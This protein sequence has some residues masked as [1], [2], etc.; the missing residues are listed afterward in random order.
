MKMET[1]P[2]KR[3]ILFGREIL[4]FRLNELFYSNLALLIPTFGLISTWHFFNGQ[5]LWANRKL[6]RNFCISIDNFRF[7][8][9][10]PLFWSFCLLMIFADLTWWYCNAVI[11]I[12]APVTVYSFVFLWHSF[13]LFIHYHEKELLESCHSKPTVDDQFCLFLIRVWGPIW[14]DILRDGFHFIIVLIFLLYLNVIYREEEDIRSLISMPFNGRLLNPPLIFDRRKQRRRIRYRRST[15]VFR[16]V[17]RRTGQIHCRLRR[18]R[19]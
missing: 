10:F 15:F 1:I 19:S 18:Y 13:L 9:H 3:L 8:W 7:S 6:I 5:S 14:F 2:I 11:V 12:M 17:L 4:S 16:Y